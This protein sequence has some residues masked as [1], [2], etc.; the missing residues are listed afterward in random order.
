MFPITKWL[1]VFLVAG[2]T[3]VPLAGHA[4]QAGQAPIT[5]KSV[6]IDLPTGE[7][8]F[9]GDAKAEAINNNCLACHS[10]GMVLNQP[11]MPKA[12][13]ETEVHKMINVYKAPVAAEDVPAIVEYL[14]STKGSK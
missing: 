11:A 13:W 6:T 2:A 8:M 3:I 4:Q 14:A 1:P 5:F 12:A 7:R 10:A 9:P